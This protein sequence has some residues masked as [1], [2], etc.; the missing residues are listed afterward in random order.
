MQTLGRGVLEQLAQ[1]ADASTADVYDA[2]FEGLR[3]DLIDCIAFLDGETSSQVAPLV[4]LLTSLQCECSHPVG[5]G[6][7][8]GQR[9]CLQDFRANHQASVFRAN[10]QA[11]VRHIISCRIT[12]RMLLPRQHAQHCRGHGPDTSSS[13]DRGG[14][15]CTFEPWLSA[16]FENARR[17]VLAQMAS[18]AD[19]W[20][21]LRARGLQDLAPSFVRTGVFSLEA[22][23]ENSASLQG[24]GVARWQ[25]DML[26]GQAT[27]TAGNNLLPAGRH[28]LPPV[29]KRR[30]ASLTDALRAAQPDQRQAALDELDSEVLARRMAASRFGGS[31]VRPGRWRLLHWMPPTSDVWQLPSR[32]EDIEAQP[33]IFLPSA[34]G[35]PVTCTLN[36]PNPCGSSCICE[37]V[38]GAFD[39][40]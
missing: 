27:P 6:F 18:A 23:S 35:R 7:L 10:H 4:E 25:I 14:Q 12:I 22:V 32:G 39:E 31:C 36:Y 37:T 13:H 34:L 3:H 30:R 28:D 8:V 9:G 17:P 24:H 1:L 29:R 5:T 33:N 38:S 19:L 20:A 40:A 15:G 11:S 2:Q 26:M 21:A 16:P